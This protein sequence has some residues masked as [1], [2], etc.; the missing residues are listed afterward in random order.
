M[1][2][3]SGE[4]SA[5]C[6]CQF[7][8]GL[9][10][11]VG[12]KETHVDAAVL[13]PVALSGDQ[14]ELDGLSIAELQCCEFCKQDPWCPS[15]PP[16]PSIKIKE[17]LTGW[18]SVYYPRK[19][20]EHILLLHNCTGQ[21]FAVDGN[22]VNKSQDLGSGTTCDQGVRPPVVEEEY[23]VAGL[24]TSIWR[25]T[26]GGQHLVWC[27]RFG[28][29]LPTPAASCPAEGQ[30]ILEEQ[31]EKKLRIQIPAQPEAEMLR[32]EGAGITKAH[33]AR[34]P[35]RA[36]QEA[37][38]PKWSSFCS[39]ECGLERYLDITESLPDA[40][41]TFGEGPVQREGVLLAPRLGSL[42]H[43]Y[44]TGARASVVLVVGTVRSWTSAQGGKET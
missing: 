8:F 39:P 1:G 15:G 16:A 3:S 11:S 4:E 42:M 31:E 30:N 44:K 20:S 40:N 34:S 6:L 37:Y 28:P 22:R 7:C 32:S 35:R 17:A 21:M 41:L 27:L 26:S 10:Y 14:Q 25:P 18:F 33:A 36:R 29:A 13:V 12:W 19:E 2:D 9:G 43:W 38:W 23:W 5:H 24:E